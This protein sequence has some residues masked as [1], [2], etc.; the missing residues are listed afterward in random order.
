MEPIIE[1][2]YKGRLIGL[3]TGE[4]RAQQ[5][6]DAHM[7]G[8]KIIDV[9]AH[10]VEACDFLGALLCQARKNKDN[11]TFTDCLY[12]LRELYQQMQTNSDNKSRSEQ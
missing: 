4:I 3:A 7:K 2:T 5:L 12:R 8:C 9:V 6:I 10:P 11:A 1:V